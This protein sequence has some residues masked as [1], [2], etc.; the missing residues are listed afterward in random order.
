MSSEDGYNVKEGSKKT[1]S[2]GSVLKASP[3]VC[4]FRVFSVHRH[5]NWY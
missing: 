1:L 3:Q 2:P 4:S 5:R